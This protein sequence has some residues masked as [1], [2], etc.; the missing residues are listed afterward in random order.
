MVKLFKNCPVL[1]DLTIDGCYVF[2]VLEVAAPALKI[3]RL[4]FDPCSRSFEHN[5]LINCPKLENLVL[6]GN[7]SANYCL[8]QA[9]SLVTASQY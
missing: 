6:K 3:L 5:Y 8:G 9:E 4:R 7:V 1:E 2:S